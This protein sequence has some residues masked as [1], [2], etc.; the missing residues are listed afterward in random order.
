MKP[1][2]TSALFIWKKKWESN[3]CSPKTA[4]ET[5]QQCTDF[6]PNIAKIL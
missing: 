3:E 4:I 6:L 5:L 1:F 2:L